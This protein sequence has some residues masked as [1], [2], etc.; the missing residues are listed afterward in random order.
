M[1]I[2]VPFPPQQRLGAMPCSSTLRRTPS[3]MLHRLTPSQI[4]PRIPQRPPTPFSPPPSSSTPPYPLSVSQPLSHPTSPLKPS[5]THF[6]CT[7]KSSLVSSSSQLSSHKCVLFPPCC[8]CCC[9]PTSSSL[10]QSE[11]ERF[12]QYGFDWISL[13]GGILACLLPSTGKSSN[14]SSSSSCAAA[15]LVAGGCLVESEESEEG[16]SLLVGALGCAAPDMVAAVV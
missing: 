2:L 14:S 15:G 5:E 12:G 7:E 13:C 10:D 9:A 11:P 1:F 16:W 3:L 4:P 8:C 6:N